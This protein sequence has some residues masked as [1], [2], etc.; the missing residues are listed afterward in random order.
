MRL[1]E[2]T[3]KSIPTPE[4]WPP[5]E[6]KRGYRLTWDSDLKGF[7]LRTTIAGVNSFV[8]NYRTEDGR[9]RRSTIGRWPAMTATAARVA[10]VRLRSKVDGGGDPL[11]AQ[12]ARRGD[13]TFAQ[14]VDE[15][16][17][18]HLSQ[19]RSGRETERVLRRDAIPTLGRLKASAVRRRDV[20]ALVEGKASSAPVAANRLLSAISRAY[21]WALRRELIETGNPASLVLKAP[22]GTRDRV[23]TAGEL[24]QVWER[25]DDAPRLGPDAATALRLILLTLAR[26]G[27]VVGMR[28]TEL[29][30]DWW[31]IPGARTKNR[32]AHRVP[33]NSLAK[34]ILEDRS[35]DS[36]FV[37]PSD[38][39]PHLARLSLSHAIRRTR[40]HFGVLPFTPHDLR[41]TA[42]SHIAA[43]G[44]P[45]FVV[46]R[47]LNHTD[48]SVTSVYD[49][50]EYTREKRQAAEHWGRFVNS[51]LTGNKSSLVEF[52]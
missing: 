30:N 36:E 44:T 24:V 27:E 47:L 25:L 22:E 48:R 14:L 37:F 9:Q 23:L 32:R 26:P 8:Y 45:R 38:Q 16:A 29:D 13:L 41:R 11:A 5:E 3:I 28:W 33:L 10:A 42:A 43:L 1:N 46:E 50:Y 6:T 4:R 49:R 2:R 35:R 7:G 19:Q 12:Q 21:N 52:A 40:K 15:F 20:I 17:S 18:S 34:T 51:L 31:E 39:A